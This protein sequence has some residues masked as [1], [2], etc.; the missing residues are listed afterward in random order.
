[1]TLNKSLILLASVAFSLILQT[2]G[3]PI[4]VKYPNQLF[5]Y[6]SNWRNNFAK[7]SELIADGRSGNK[8]YVSQSKASAGDNNHDIYAYE[9]WFYGVKNGIIVE[10]GALDGLLF[11]TSHMFEHYANWTA[12][13]VEADLRNYQALCANRQNSINVNCAL[14]DTPMTLH[15]VS[16]HATGT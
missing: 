12:I 9:N 10:S 16:G 8:S 7:S 4:R 3:S 13:H 2:N 15:Y 11:S 5:T 14:C 6:N 1:M